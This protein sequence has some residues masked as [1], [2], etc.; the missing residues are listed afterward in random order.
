MAMKRIEF[1][2]S[3]EVKEILRKEIRRNDDARYD[4]RL[5]AVLL[6]VDGQ[7]PYEVAELLGD[8]PRSIYNWITR[9]RQEGLEGLREEERPGRP[10]RLTDRQTKALAQDLVRSPAD[11]GYGQPIWDGALLSYHVEKRFGVSLGVR[12]CQ[13][14]FHNLGMRLL[15]PRTFPKG[16][17]LEKQAEFKKTDCIAERAGHQRLGGG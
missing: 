9:F 2:D 4:H 13:R 17:D 11:F 1:P 5:H 8:S 3:S 6:A 10:S 14:V 7:S 12:Q 15:R 16:A